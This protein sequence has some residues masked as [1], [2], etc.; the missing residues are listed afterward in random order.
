MTIRHLYPAVEPSLNL[1]FANSRKLDS[2]ITFTRASTGTYTDESGIIRTAAAN[3]ARFDHD[4]DG[5]SLGLLIEESRANLLTYSQEFDDASWKRY[6]NSTGGGGGLTII[7]NSGIAPDGTSTAYSSTFNLNDG[8]QLYK[9]GTGLAGVEYTLSIWIRANPSIDFTLFFYDNISLLQSET[10]SS[11]TEWQRFTLTKTYGSGSTDRRIGIQNATGSFYLW[12]AQLET[13][14]FP[15]SYIPTTSSTVT[16]SADVASMTGTN[17][18]SWYNQ[19]EGTVLF[20]A[21]TLT[22]ATKTFLYVCD[23]SSAINERI[24]HETNSLSIRSSGTTIINR[25]ISAYHPYN[26]AIAYKVNDFATSD[27]GSVQTVSSGAV[28]SSVDIAYFYH[29]I[30]SQVHPSGHISRLTYYPVRLPD[31]QLQALTL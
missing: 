30:Y 1:D 10:F 17:F 31:T 29:P 14:S 25:S 16:R 12:G 27:R 5:N 7:P 28:P 20:K 4:G 26:S 2:R 21:T 18:S 9:N 8:A 15:T 3:E 24:I 22:T 23:A 6:S 13:G 19:S 11:S